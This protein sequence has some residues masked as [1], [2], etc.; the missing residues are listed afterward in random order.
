MTDG[1]NLADNHLGKPGGFKH[2]LFGYDLSYR[3]NPDTQ[4]LTV[5]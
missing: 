3:Q 1:L 5:E 2:L 4:D